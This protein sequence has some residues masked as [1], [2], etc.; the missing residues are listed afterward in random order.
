M[1]KAEKRPARIGAGATTIRQAEKTPRAV[2]LHIEELVLHGFSRGERFEIGDAVE[3]ELS[4]LFSEPDN[5]QSLAETASKDSVDGGSF[6][7]SQGA[8]S[9]AI[10]TQVANAVYGGLAR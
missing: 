5:S 3:R 1:R 7:I 8:R 9:A 6:R 4:R 10:G 2:N